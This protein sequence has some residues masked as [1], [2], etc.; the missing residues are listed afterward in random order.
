M[1]IC[2]VNALNF[3]DFEYDLYFMFIQISA[4][5]NYYLESVRDCLSILN[6][7]SFVLKFV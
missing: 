2:Y 5:I 6:M 4:L 1:H 7:I 3:L